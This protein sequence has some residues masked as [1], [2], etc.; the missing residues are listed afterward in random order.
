MKRELSYV[1]EIV[2][3][4][5]DFMKYKIAIFLSSYFTLCDKLSKIEIVTEKKILRSVWKGFFFIQYF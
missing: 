1:I 2:P 5:H 4:I 3:D